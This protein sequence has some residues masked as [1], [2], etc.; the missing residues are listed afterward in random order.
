MKF[1][2]AVETYYFVKSKKRAI[3]P[4]IKEYPMIFTAEKKVPLNFQLKMQELSESSSH[5]RNSENK[6]RLSMQTRMT[7]VDLRRNIMKLVLKNRENNKLFEFLNPGEDED[8][9]NES[10]NWFYIDDE[11]QEI[12]GPLNN[13]EMQKLFEKRK[14]MPLT[15]IKKKLMSDFVQMRYLLNKFCRLKAIQSIDE[16]QFYEHLSKT[17]PR[18]QGVSM[19]RELEDWLAI[20][21]KKI[22]MDPRLPQQ[23]QIFFPEGSDS[24]SFTKKERLSFVV[25]K[26]N[27]KSYTSDRDSRGLFENID[28]KKTDNK[29]RMSFD[30]QDEKKGNFNKKRSRHATANY[31]VK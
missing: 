10:R 7:K 21:G 5:R 1:E 16:G 13:Q 23:M 4:L 3:K 18:K 11:S 25:S 22:D 31:K 30:Q 17:S 24:S 29:E 8:E 15:Y 6:I 28:I 27:F 19:E 20:I 12:I 9:E 26:Q 2:D 14:L